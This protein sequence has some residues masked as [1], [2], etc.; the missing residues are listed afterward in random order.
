MKPIMPRILL[1]L[2]LFAPMVRGEAN[3]MNHRAFDVPGCNENT[4]IDTYAGMVPEDFHLRV[5]EDGC[6]RKWDNTRDWGS[7]R[8]VQ[9]LGLADLIG[10]AHETP[11]PFTY[12]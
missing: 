12:H 9:N 11:K 4:A 7:A 1:L 8:Q 3:M 5:T 2:V 10:T 6:Y